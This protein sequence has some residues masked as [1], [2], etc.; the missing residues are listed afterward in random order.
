MT[1]FPAGQYHR[2][3][4][5]NCCVRD[6]NRCCPGLVITDKPSNPAFA[7]ATILE[8]AAAVAAREG[9]AGP[10]RPDRTRAE[11]PSAA[12]R[13][14][15]PAGRNRALNVTLGSCSLPR[16]KSGRSDQAISTV[17][18]APLRVFLP[19]HARPI[20]LVVF[21]GSLAFAS[22]SCLEG[23]FT[24]RCLQR[25][26]LPHVATQRCAKRRNWITRGGSNP[27]LSY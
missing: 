14:G 22:R 12:D 10:W 16:T 24:L 2:Q 4:R 26:S 15:G 23:G 21:Q 18:T 11:E 1:Y 20:N 13:A 6:G 27:V 17:S 3:S 9:E 25:L 8:S 5:L 7:E 19:V